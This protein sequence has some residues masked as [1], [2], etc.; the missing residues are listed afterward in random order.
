MD[1]IDSFYDFCVVFVCVVFAH[2]IYVLSF[3]GCH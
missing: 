3:S 1:A 2:L